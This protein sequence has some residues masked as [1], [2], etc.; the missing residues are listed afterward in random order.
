[1]KTTTVLA[2]V[3]SMLAILPSCSLSQWGSEHPRFRLLSEE[4]S[5]YGGREFVTRRY[6]VNEHPLETYVET[7]QVGTE[8]AV[9]GS[10]GAVGL[11]L[12]TNRAAAY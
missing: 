11:A 3:L 1:M 12:V 9:A 4:R 5:V 7:L 2:A 8:W 6:L 10:R